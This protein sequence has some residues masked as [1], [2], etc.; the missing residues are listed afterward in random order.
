MLLLRRQ[1]LDI[2]HWQDDQ[3][4]YAFVNLSLEAAGRCHFS[5]MVNADMYWPVLLGPVIEVSAESPIDGPMSPEI[6]LPSPPPRPPPRPPMPGEY[7]GMPPLT[8]DLPPMSPTTTLS[9]SSSGVRPH[10]A[11]EVFDGL[12]P[13][14]PFSSRGLP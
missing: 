7:Y 13:N 14:T 10:W 3:L 11:V 2:R 12:Q 9:S 4:D 1:I 8:P 6:P 5:L